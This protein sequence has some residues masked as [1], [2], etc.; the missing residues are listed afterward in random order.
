MDRKKIPLL[1]LCILI[2]AVFWLIPTPVGLEDNSWHFLGLFIAVIMAVILQVMP[3]GAVCMIAIA[4]VALSGI[5]TTQ[6]SVRAT[7]I[8]TLEGI[9]LRDNSNIYKTT[10]DEAVEAATLQALINAN[11]SRN[12]KAKVD[13]IL[14][15]STDVNYQIEN[16]SKI[17]TKATS[18]TS[19][20]QLIDETK[21]SAL[22][23][24]ALDFLSQKSID[25]KVNTAISNLKSKTG[26][27]DALSGFSN[28]LIWLIVISIIV[29]RGVIKTGLG[30]RLA[31]HFI[32]IFGKKTLG[33]AYSI[34]F[35]ETILAPVTPSNT[36]RAGAIINPI[37]QAIARSFKSTP[38]D[39][40]QN[41]IGTYLSLVNYQANPI[42]SAMFITATAPNP[43]VVDLIAQATN[44]E[45]HLTWG[46]WAL[47]MF[48]PGIAAMLLMPLV[49]Y[50]LSPPEIKSTPN[51]SAFAKDKLKELGK[52]KN[53]EKIMLSVFVL[54]LLLWAGALGLFFGISLDATSVALLGLSL[55][56]I[57][58]VLTFGEVLAEKA[59]W[60]TLVWFSALVMM[61]TL[62]GKLGVTQFLAEALGEF[63]SAM[64]LGEISIMIFLSLA[65][66]YTH[67]FFASTTAHISAMFF[68]FYSAGLA[69]GAPPLLYAFIMIAS[70]NVMMA[71]TH[72]A[73][74]TAPVIFGTGYVTLK[75]WWSIGFVISIVDIVVMIAVGLI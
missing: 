10:M 4:I 43:L 23:T 46:Q 69:L 33:I 58:G 11:I 36:A 51:A 30:E 2:A 72:Y 8:K 34:A 27:K 19:T 3:L 49:L 73:T 41:K 44:L 52:M 74:G 54:L 67:Y 45:V 6:S 21:I 7:H 39:G 64:G 62:L 42:S 16:L 71:L 1:V 26:I 65:F 60:N 75:K 18:K 13:E 29:A 17:Y 5:T 24:L 28:S 48:L 15:S 20:Q 32:S 61:A 40:T 37:V 57:S 9:V 70:G 50:F 12:L 68:V 35:C 14:K 59:A 38:E 53:S 47:G 56:L 22:N 66:L 63:A 25:E 55:V 31:Y